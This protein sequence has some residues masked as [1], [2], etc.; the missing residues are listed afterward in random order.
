MTAPRRIDFS[1]VAKVA[2]AWIPF[3]ILWALFILG[4]GGGNLRGALLSGTYATIPAAVFGIGVWRFSGRYA[5]PDP[6]RASFYGVHLAAAIGYAVAWAAAG[7]ALAMLVQGGTLAEYLEN[8]QV[9]SWRLLMGVWLYI[10]IAGVSYSLRNRQQVRRQEQITAQAE[11]VAARA[12]LEALKAQLHPHFLFNALHSVSALIRID[13]ERAEEAMEQL[14]D[15]LR[16]ALEERGTAFVTLRDEWD[17]TCDYLRLQQ[18]RFGEKL[19]AESIV[20]PRALDCPIPPFTV[21][22]LVENA[23]HHGIDR[24]AEGGRVAIVIRR[25]DT[26]VIIEVRDDGPGLAHVASAPGTG[27]G[28]SVLRERLAFLYDGQSQCTI[29]C[30]PDGGTVATLV[31]PYRAASE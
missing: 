4:Y 2:L 15:L 1:V 20:D 11:A 21:Q 17:F 9:Y 23:V 31:L 29:A 30:P 27:H 8:P 6:V 5:W 10:I 7:I 28:L 12:R 3:F 14:G 24:R 19:H 13:Q 25:E 18:L 26:Q 22:P 16:Y